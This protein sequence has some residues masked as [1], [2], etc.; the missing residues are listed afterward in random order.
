[1]EKLKEWL[2]T[3]KW[4][5]VLV[6]ALPLFLVY[7]LYKKYTGSTGSA[8]SAT[9]SLAYSPGS[10]GG[11][12]SSGVDNSSALTTLQNAVTG[13]ANQQATDES[14]NQSFMTKVTAALT[15]LTSGQTAENAQEQTDVATL[16][17]QNKS[18]LS[19]VTDA[20]SNMTA[21][22]S[23][24]AANAGLT[25]VGGITTTTASGVRETT[26][27]AAGVSE[28]TNAP[29]ASNPWG[30]PTINPGPATQAQY[31]AVTEDTALTEAENPVQNMVANA[32]NTVLGD[33]AT[34]AN[35]PGGSAAAHQNAVNTRNNLAA[36]LAGNTEGYTTSWVP[37]GQGYSQLKVTG[38]NGYNQL[39]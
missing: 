26:T 39:I 36:Q 14:N 23:S 27:T 12:G 28:T 9:G 11:G 16:A 6:I 33:E 13:L 29:S 19:Q 17:N 22:L 1:M 4:A 3:H 7:Y 18:I 20:I 15:Q 8:G 21:K 24:M 37:T 25:G 38:P 32:L 30:L 34:Y 5:W 2:R 35:T 10:S 31:N